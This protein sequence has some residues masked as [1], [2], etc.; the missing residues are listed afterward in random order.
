LLLA[1]LTIATCSFTEGNDV[2]FLKKHNQ[3]VDEECLRGKANSE[4]RPVLEKIIQKNPK[5]A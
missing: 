4:C 1:T 5:A 3:E 2:F